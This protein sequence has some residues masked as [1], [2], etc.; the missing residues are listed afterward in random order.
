MQITT[1]LKYTIKAPFRRLGVDLVVRRPDPFDF[2]RPMGIRTVLDVG[3]YRGV[4]AEE[5]RRVLPEAA[6]HAFEPLP[7][8]RAH[9]QRLAENDTGLHVW[10][11]AVGAECG[12]FDLHIGRKDA[13]S[14]FFPEGRMCKYFSAA[15]VISSVPVEMTT[16]D[17][18]ATRVALQPPVM[19]KADVQGFEGQVVR[20]AARVLEQTTVVLLEVSFEELYAG[21]PLFDDIYTLMRGH[22]FA[23]AGMVQ[24]I[25]ECGT[26]RQLQSNAIFTRPSVPSGPV[27]AGRVA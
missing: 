4:F 26:G 22:G 16:L 20:G 24:P 10:N 18:W 19:L 23:L 3:A 5:V 9:L 17:H 15:A 7:E 1:S 8:P 13:T 2:L 11:V 21:Q 27:T 12:T 25:H 6:I 14:S